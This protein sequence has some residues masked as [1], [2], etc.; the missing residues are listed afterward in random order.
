MVLAH[1]RRSRA[2]PAHL[3]VLRHLGPGASQG[4]G[5]GPG[6][7]DSHL[8]D[9]SAGPHRPLRGAPHRQGEP[10]PAPERPPRPRR[11]PASA[12]R[13]QAACRPHRGPDPHGQGEPPDPHP[14]RPRRAVPGAERHLR[15]HAPRGD[16][17]ADQG[18]ASRWPA[19]PAH[20][21][22]AHPARQAARA[23]RGRG[24]ADPRLPGQGQGGPGRLGQVQPSTPRSRPQRF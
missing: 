24:E 6:G 4:P 16:R 10:Q 11:P 18:P 14:C 9:A 3:G 15:L 12:G 13:G 17:L 19:R 20:R 1:D 21:R 22:A 7:G 2:L 23:A 8:R 5:V